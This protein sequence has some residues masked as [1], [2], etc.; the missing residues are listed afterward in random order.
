MRS[1]SFPV[2]R[3]MGVQIRIH[4]FFLLLLACSVVYT[5]YAGISPA[6]GVMLWVVLLMAV[7]IREA[8]RGLIAVRSGLE[9]RNMLL[10]PIGGLFTH[11]TPESSERASEGGI[12]T[13]L[14]VV[15]PLANLLAALTVAGLI[16]AVSP[17]QGLIDKPW[18]TPLHLMRSF[19]WLN[20]FLAAVNMFPAY[21]MDAGKLVRGGM[22]KSRPL[23][24]ATKTASGIGQ[25]LAFLTFAA[26]LV[27]LNP[28]LIFGGM[29]I[30]LAAHLEDQGVF[31]QAVVDTIQMKDVML[32]EFSTL[33]PADTLEYALQ[34]AMHSLQEDFPVVRGDLLVGVV[35]RQLLVDAMQT[36]GNGYGQ[37]VMTKAFQVAQPGDTLGAAFRRISNGR[38]L[39]LVPVMDGDRVIGIVTLQNLMHSMGLL[40]ETRRIQRQQQ[41]TRE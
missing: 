9:I 19:V 1:W 18:V 20:V 28:W 7:V 32:T 29:F 13:R 10:L 40:A 15:G 38:G 30:F 12:Q 39:S 14:A 34:K 17:A 5:N 33:S 41:L 23:L 4:L 2:G 11:Q 37:S 25:A 3:V 21:P 36:E 6:R 8:A 27:L 24:Q 22:S 26:G 31:F 35:S 16:A